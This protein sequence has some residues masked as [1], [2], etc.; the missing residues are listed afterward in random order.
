MNRGDDGGTADSECIRRRSRGEDGEGEGSGKTTARAGEGITEARSKVFSSPPPSLP[1]RPQGSDVKKKKIRNDEMGA[2]GPSS[3]RFRS[4]ILLHGSESGMDDPTVNGA[5]QHRSFARRAHPGPLLPCV[6]ESERGIQLAGA[7]EPTKMKRTPKA[8]VV[9]G[10]IAGLSCAHA[11]MSAGWQV[12][13]IEKSGAA[14]S[15]SPTGAGLGLDPQSLEI[16]GRWISNPD[17]LRDITLSLSIDLVL[18][19]SPPTIHFSFLLLLLFFKKKKIFQAN[20]SLRFTRFSFPRFFF[21]LLDVKKIYNNNFMTV[22]LTRSFLKKCY[23]VNFA[24][25]Y[26]FYIIDNIVF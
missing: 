23:C 9:G 6:R 10:S 14:P 26:K 2:S 25:F 13:V 18:C 5:K 15:G 4:V 7:M 20:I 24:D 17:L 22:I 19:G 21:M 11:L 1:F 12:T 16:V 8:V 3:V